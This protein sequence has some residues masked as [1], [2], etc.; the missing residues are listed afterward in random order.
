MTEVPEKNTTTAEREEKENII[1]DIFKKLLEI[2]W[3]T[4]GGKKQVL[5]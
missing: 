5:K 1:I 2:N 3:F 4:Y